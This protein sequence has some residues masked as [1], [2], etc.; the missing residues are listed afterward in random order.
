MKKLTPLV[1]L[2]LTLAAADTHAA[3]KFPSDYI[4]P[5]CG[6]PVNGS[7]SV[8][9]SGCRY[10]AEQLT[11]A[12]AE[13]RQAAL[14]SGTLRWDTQAFGSSHFSVGRA[15]ARRVAPNDVERAD[16]EVWDI[17]EAPGDGRSLSVTVHERD[18]GTVS[19]TMLM[20]DRREVVAVTARRHAGI[21]QR[22]VYLGVDDALSYA[23]LAAYIAAHPR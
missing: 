3:L 10:E 12:A 19:V 22:D 16:I 21:G 4:P 20:T 23:R 8:I 18:G 13:L 9:G 11:E 15:T 1:A 5:D 2:M 6:A 14:R 17:I 7:Y